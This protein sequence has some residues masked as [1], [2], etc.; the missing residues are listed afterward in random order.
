MRFG[1]IVRPEEG[2][3]IYCPVRGVVG[4]GRGKIEIVN[5]GGKGREVSCRCAISLF[6]ALHRPRAIIF[7]SR[8]KAFLP[9]FLFPSLLSSVSISSSSA[10]VVG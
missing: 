9:F 8:E 10:F 2:S 3:D 1:G 5:L 4:Q 6:L 7:F